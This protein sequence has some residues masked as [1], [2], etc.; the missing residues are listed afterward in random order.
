MRGGT[1]FC[2][3]PC[4]YSFFKRYQYQKSCHSR[5][6]LYPQK[7]STE[8]SISGKAVVGLEQSRLFSPSSLLSFYSLRFSLLPVNL[9]FNP[10]FLILSFMPQTQ[11]LSHR[12]KTSTSYPR[13]R[14]NLSSRYSRWGTHG[15]SHLIV[16]Q[17]LFFF[18]WMSLT[19]LAIATL[20]HG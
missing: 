8:L 17:L 7:L 19:Y 18:I 9:H 20:F 6:H 4:V 13:D 16:C 1:G 2:L 11:L 10:P 12:T 5:T 15:R 14:D 3:I